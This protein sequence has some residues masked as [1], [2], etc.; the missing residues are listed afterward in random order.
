VLPLFGQNCS[1]PLHLR[2]C[3]NIPVTGEYVI[4]RRRVLI[5]AWGQIESITKRVSPPTA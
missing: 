3:E 2:A 5:R 1:T 4:G